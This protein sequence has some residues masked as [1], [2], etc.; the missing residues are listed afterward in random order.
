MTSIP[1]RRLILTL[2]LVFLLLPI[3]WLINM[4][5]KTNTEIV[6]ALATVPQQVEATGVAIAEIVQ[7]TPTSNYV[8]PTTAPNSP[9]VVSGMADGVLSVGGQSYLIATASTSRL[10]LTSAF[11]F[12]GGTLGS[13]LGSLVAGPHTD[14]KSITIR[15]YTF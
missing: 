14:C 13:S 6:S 2:F 9:P 8:A 12:L 11:Y 4:S 7:D 10:G 1:G 5:L 15:K 3:Y